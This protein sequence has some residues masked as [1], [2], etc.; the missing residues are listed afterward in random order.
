MIVEE[1]TGSELYSFPISTIGVLIATFP[2]GTEVKGI[3]TVVG[4]N[5]VLTAFDLLYNDEYGGWVETL[6]GYFGSDFNTESGRFDNRGTIFPF[7]GWSI[8]RIQ[9][10]SG[11]SGDLAL[12]GTY[13]N[14]GAE[15][16]GGVGS[17]AGFEFLADSAY[18]YPAEGSGFSRISNLE[19]EVG[20]L[21]FNR[22][23]ELGSPIF[24]SDGSLIGIFTGAV[25]DN[26]GWLGDY[27]ENYLSTYNTNDNL[28]RSGRLPSWDLN[29]SWTGSGITGEGPYYVSEGETLTYT[30][31]DSNLVADRIEVRVTGVAN[32]SDITHSALETYYSH[33]SGS[34]SFETTADQRTEGLERLVIET[35]FF[36]LEKDFSETIT[37]DIFIRDTS[38]GANSGLASPSGEFTSN[39]LQSGALTLIA[40]LFGEI[41]LLKGL[42]FNQATD[43]I[44][45]NG[46]QFEYGAVDSFVMTV[47]NNG[48]FT[49]EFSQEIS[50]SFPLHTGISYD[51]AVALV[52]VNNIDSTLLGVA[53]ADGNYVG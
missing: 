33:S 11:L 42:S 14:L 50:E 52:G 5:D 26:V 9:D 39:L 48:S 49:E 51:T 21:R 15:L 8:S 27:W 36:D 20:S 23:I 29:V 13:Q 6:D 4:Q 44:T 43:A 38:L 34:I 45:Y 28:F 17:S 25:S 24:N 40:D 53:G 16:T 2:D 12:I 32:T 18:G 47:T 19:G 30:A 37:D 35:T 41:K 22:D 10:S 1:I 7:N 46:R 3:G 31:S